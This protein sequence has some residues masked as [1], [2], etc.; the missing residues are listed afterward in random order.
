MTSINLNAMA[1]GQSGA[2]NSAFEQA[3][4]A[5]GSIAQWPLIR[6]TVRFWD[7]YRRTAE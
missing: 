5:L 6:S 7:S 4:R 2:G 3:F 1:G